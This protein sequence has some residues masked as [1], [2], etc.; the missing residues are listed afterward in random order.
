MKAL[1]I[2]TAGALARIE[3]ATGVDARLPQ[4]QAAVG[5]HIEFLDLTDT[6]TMILNEEGKFEDPIPVN[7]V[8]TALT[9]A[10]EVGML[11][12]DF[13]AGDI[14]LAGMDEDG[15]LTDVPADVDELLALL[16]P[17]KE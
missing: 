5:G 4:L 6:L 12:G 10:Y 8:A 11:P 15:E 16:I 7:P 14:V 2:T 17:T 13:I 9:I 3:L 1:T